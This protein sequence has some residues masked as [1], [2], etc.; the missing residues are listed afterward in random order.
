[1]DYL[2]NK[3]KQNKETLETC[4]LAHESGD[5]SW[6]SL[7]SAFYV[8]VVKQRIG[9]GTGTTLLTLD[10]QATETEKRQ[11]TLADTLPQ[12]RSS[13]YLRQ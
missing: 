8:T 7:D 9:S 1:M 12:T 13:Y 5:F 3:A 4:S 6:W 2:K 10:G 11:I